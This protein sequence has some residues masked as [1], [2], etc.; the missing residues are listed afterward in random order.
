[1]NLL[2]NICLFSFIVVSSNFK[3]I[4]KDTKIFNSTSKS[5]VDINNK[6][7]IEDYVLTY[8]KGSVNL[9]NELKNYDIILN[10]NTYYT[11]ILLFSDSDFSN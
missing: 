10:K 8:D 7:I 4:I 11:F 6:I 2:L 1:M 9:N 3:S 5:A